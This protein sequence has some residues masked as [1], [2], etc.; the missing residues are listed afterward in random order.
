MPFGSLLVP[1][2]LARLCH[3]VCDRGR[4]IHTSVKSMRVFIEIKGQIEKGIKSVW[5]TDI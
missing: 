4:W 2:D 5:E 3:P 1:W